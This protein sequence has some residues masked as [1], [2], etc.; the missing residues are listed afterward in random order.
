MYTGK[1][2][3][4]EGKNIDQHTLNKLY[5]WVC[6][7]MKTVGCGRNVMYFGRPYHKVVA[8][9]ALMVSKSEVKPF[10]QALLF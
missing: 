10:W 6:N 5:R 7:G 3:T 4:F 2:Y 9:F 1:R 8:R